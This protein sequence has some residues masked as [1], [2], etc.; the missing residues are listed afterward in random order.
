MVRMPFGIAAAALAAIALASGANAI[1]I[2]VRASGAFGS[3]SL[4]GVPL[5]VPAGTSF[6]IA[7]AY[8]TQL[9]GSAVD[10]MFVRYRPVNPARIVIGGVR[11]DAPF[12]LEAINVGSAGILVGV[13]D[14]GRASAG[15]MQG[16]S[17]FSE[18]GDGVISNGALPA[19]PGFFSRY[20]FQ[21]QAY[22]VSDPPLQDEDPLLAL[23]F[24]DG[25]IVTS[26]AA[27]PE[28]ASWGM[29]IAGLALAGAAMRGRRARIAIRAMPAGL[30]AVRTPH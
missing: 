27:V 5:F 2:K 1:S 13:F 18:F 25:R 16:L 15:T 10:A 8:D 29:M 23:S 12:V 3:A 17:L 9:P 11:Y 14:F 22:S 20:G 6:S 28:P 24:S 26:A 19:D 30:R 7:F 4:S 21:A